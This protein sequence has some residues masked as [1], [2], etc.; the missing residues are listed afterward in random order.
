VAP[1]VT[2]ATYQAMIASTLG[3]PA[4]AAAVTAEYP[5]SADP[6][7]FWPAFT[8]ASQ[9]T[10]FLVPPGSQVET[11]YPPSIRVRSG[12]RP[13]EPR[14]SSSARCA[15]HPVHAVLEAVVAHGPDVNPRDAGRFQV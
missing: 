7:P 2:A 8:S 15:P 11:D 12:R 6:S 9:Q 10:L 3:V 14:R 1:P 13:A 5:L 4:V